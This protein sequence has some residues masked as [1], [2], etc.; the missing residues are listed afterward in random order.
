[1][2]KNDKPAAV[3]MTLLVWGL[4]GALFGGL[5]AA[6]YGLL[7]LSELAAWQAVLFG[8]LIAAVTTTAFYSS[9]PVALA[10]SMAGVLGSVGSLMAV[11]SG[12]DLALITGVAGAVGLVTGS[13]YAWLSQGGERPLAES[14]AGLVCGLVAGGLL[15]LLLALLGPILAMAVM[16][17]MIVAVVGGLF[18]V[19]EKILVSHIV[20]WCPHVISAPV[21]AGVIAAVIGASFW[22][23]GGATGLGPNLGASLAGVLDE[24]P[25]GMI[26]GMIGGAVTSILL[27]LLGAHLEDHEQ[28]V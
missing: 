17:A 1:M 8:T 13:L 14:L 10:G 19:A 27:E 5:F 21:V 11:G 3:I 9:M 18:Q 23:M 25:S 15:A 24:I 20:R 4:A 22:V 2:K 12:V 6:L 16:A 28:A 7:L 26:G